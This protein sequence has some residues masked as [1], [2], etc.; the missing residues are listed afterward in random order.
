M[1]V[2]KVFF[3]FFQMQIMLLALTTYNAINCAKVI[4]SALK[5]KNID[6]INTTLKILKLK[7]F[8]FILL[9]GTFEHIIDVDQF[10]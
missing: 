4:Q 1:W 10:L 5:I 6:F 9:S 2:R 8:D 3:Y 7:K